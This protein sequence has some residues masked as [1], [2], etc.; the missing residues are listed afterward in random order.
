MKYNNASIFA[1]LHKTTP[2][3]KSLDATDSIPNKPTPD[4]WRPTPTW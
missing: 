4:A 2:E 1:L 3:A